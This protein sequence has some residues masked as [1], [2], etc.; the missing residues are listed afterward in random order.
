MDPEIGKIFLKKPSSIET[1]KII[2]KNFTLE[3]DESLNS[4]P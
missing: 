4:T 3:S 2:L 1:L